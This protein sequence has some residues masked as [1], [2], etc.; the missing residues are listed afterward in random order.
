[1]VICKPDQSRVSWKATRRNDLGSRLRSLWTRPVQCADRG[2]LICMMVPV[3]RLARLTTARR[4]SRL[5]PLQRGLLLKVGGGDQEET[6]HP[7]KRQG[8]RGCWPQT[9]LSGAPMPTSGPSSPA[10]ASSSLARSLVGPKHRLAI[11]SSLLVVAEN[12]RVKF[13]VS[14]NAESGPFCADACLS[15]TDT[16]H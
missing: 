15:H 12:R 1:M 3:F 4:H 10:P 2:V 13:V 11:T 6:D 5:L 9:S 16:S 7:C 14:G 8:D